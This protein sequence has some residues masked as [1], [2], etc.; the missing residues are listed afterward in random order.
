MHHCWRG[1]AEVVAQSRAA[2]VAATCT[3]TCTF[4][5]S[6][7]ALPHAGR[8]HPLRPSTKRYSFVGFPTRK[9]R[10]R[11]FAIH[12]STSP[13]LHYTLPGPLRLGVR[14][15]HSPVANRYSKPVVA[16]TSPTD[17][18]SIARPTAPQ[19]EILHQSRARLAHLARHF[20]EARS[21]L[22]SH[23]RRHPAPAPAL[24]PTPIP[25][26]SESLGGAHQS[27]P[28]SPGKPTQ[29]RDGPR[30]SAHGP[31]S[32]RRV[33]DPHSTGSTRVGESASV[34]RPRLRVH[35]RPRLHLRC[36]GDL[37]V[38]TA[39]RTR[40]SPYSSSSTTSPVTPTRAFCCRR[41]T[42]IAEA[43][44][45]ERRKP[46]PLNPYTSASYAVRELGPRGALLSRPPRESIVIS[47]CPPQTL[48][49]ALHTP[50]LSRIHQGPWPLRR[51]PAPQLMQSL[52]ENKCALGP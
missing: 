14:V 5:P 20:R 13:S 3:C 26:P 29:P 12:S 33:R 17:T 10:P 35:P 45:S 48:S 39:D 22:A 7:G 9:R 43:H 38:A 27:R 21:G 42:T 31:R 1:G 18:T 44:D 36:T 52:L 8:W 37:P 23:T 28:G 2:V 11:H 19:L 40:A 6:G 24:A 32:L 15:G 47:A 4:I 49:S 34:L 41:E 46:T 16:S 51:S 30:S 50:A 25:K